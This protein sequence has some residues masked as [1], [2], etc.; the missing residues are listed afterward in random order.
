M[1]LPYQFWVAHDTPP[2]KGGVE[3]AFMSTTSDQETALFYSGGKGTVVEIDVGR[4]QNGGDLSWISM[5]RIYVLGLYYQHVFP[6][7]KYTLTKLS[8][9]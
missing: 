2:W 3:L 4:V 9:T 6:S 1:L 5:V 7:R 8:S